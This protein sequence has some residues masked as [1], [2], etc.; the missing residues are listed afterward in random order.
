L[1]AIESKDLFQLRFIMEARKIDSTINYLKYK[2]RFQW[3]ALTGLGEKKLGVAR[4]AKLQL[5]DTGLNILGTFHINYLRILKVYKTARGQL[6][7]FTYLPWD[8]ARVWLGKKRGAMEIKSIDGQ[9]LSHSPDLICYFDHNHKFWWMNITMLEKLGYESTELVGRSFLSFLHPDDV[10]LAQGRFTSL[11]ATGMSNPCE[12]RIRKQD[13]EYI[14]GWVV[15]RP[16]VENGENAGVVVHIRDITQ[17]KRDELRKIIDQRLNT[18]YEVW[19]GINHEFNN[20]LF[21]LLAVVD[22]FEKRLSMGKVDP[23]VALKYLE[24][25]VG[26]AGRIRGLARRLQLFA[27][28]SGQEK[29]SNDLISL[30]DAVLQHFEKKFTETGIT[31]IRR[32]WLASGKENPLLMRLHFAGIQMLLMDLLNN[33]VDA[34]NIRRAYDKNFAR[35]IRVSLQIENGKKDLVVLKIYDTGCG[36]KAEDKEGIFEP[37][38]TTKPAGKGTGL[39]MMLVQHVVQEHNG[40]IEIESVPDEWTKITV[41]FPLS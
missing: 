38:F 12:L 14:W 26:S 41:R 35:E 21:P 11:M 18:L 9:A 32:G 28:F 10:E 39:G 23:E 37:F 22:M 8:K 4:R 33:S 20:A 40:S 30:I 36:I 24:Q 19:G 17:R 3:G 2:R 16:L 1:E 13:G 15:G 5:I 6:P 7:E 25:M 31:V 27:E 29:V 34:I